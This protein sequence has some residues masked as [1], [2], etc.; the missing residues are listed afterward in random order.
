VKTLKEQV[1]K[2]RDNPLFTRIYNKHKKRRQRNPEIS[3]ERTQ[4]NAL[5][6][7]LETLRQMEQGLEPL[8]DEE[9][10]NDYYIVI[11]GK[12]MLN[13]EWKRLI[14]LQRQLGDTSLNPSP[15]WENRSVR[16]LKNLFR[17]DG[18]KPHKDKS[19]NLW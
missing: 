7:F 15:L 4:L 8:N 1:K 2:L 3:L 12:S 16:Y 17:D 14:E 6:E 13:S 5:K 9:I 19:V 18:E 10:V 11:N